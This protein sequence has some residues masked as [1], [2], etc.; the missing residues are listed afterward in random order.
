M[1]Y[2]LF[3]ILF[4]LVFSNY[5]K[6]IQTLLILAEPGDTI[7]LGKGTFSLKGSLSM[8][9][10]ENIVISGNGMDKTILSFK[11][12]TDGAEGLRVNNCKNITL[13]DFT[14]Q[15]SKGDA[16]KI[17]DVNGVIFRRVKAEWTGG[18]KAENGAYGLYP[19][20]CQNVLIEHSIAIGASDAGIYV[21]QSKN[22]IV[23]N[24]EAYHNVAGIEIENSIQADVYENYAH[25]NTGGIL[26]FDLPDLVQ[27][28]GEYIR[29]Y[30]NR[31][32][33]NNLDN[34][35][36]PGNIVGNVPAGTGI[37]ILA[38]KNVE[39]FNNQIIENKTVGTAIV[40]YFITEEPMTDSL[41]NPYTSS[42]S[43]HDNTYK[44]SKQIPSLGHE[45]GQL[46]FAKF[47]RDVPDI[48][49]D[50]MPDPQFI[51]S[52]G[53]ILDGYNLCIQNNG[54]AEFVNLEI[55]KH[56]EKWYSPFITKFSQDMTPFDCELKALA[57]TVITAN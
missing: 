10:K 40:S 28:E 47:W 57:P 5:E 45:I 18:P 54:D 6:D 1:R 26:V 55:D 17:Q 8:E 56:F 39:I 13:V 30:N 46:L 19:V 2:F 11:N 48:V 52:D 16:I 25:H 22:I 20:L 15:D 37:M 9:G 31:S 38:A 35:A 44:R 4:S 7:N 36:P 53:K 49:Y 3:A 51:D 34:F 33:Y 12:Q 50:G 29:V 23:R 14:I 32:E 41:Y 24:S 21:G 43:I 27:K 42:I